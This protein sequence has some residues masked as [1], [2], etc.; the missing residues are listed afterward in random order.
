[1]TA[2]ASTAS[3]TA[4]SAGPQP[5]SIALRV[6]L[7]SS[8]IRATATLNRKSSTAAAASATAR[9][10]TLRSP[11]SP[12]VGSA[13]TGGGDVPGQP[14]GRWPGTAPTRCGETSA[15]SMS[16]SGG[17]A[18]TIVSRTA[19]TPWVPSSSDSRT[20]L[21]RDLLMAE[22]FITTMPWFSSR[23]NGSVKSTSPGRAA[24]W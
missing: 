13:P 19:S 4:G 17:P 24:P 3:R 18:N 7:T 21:P 6:A 14:P 15:Q 9:W 22:P 5:V 23:V 10:V 1:M 16:S 8:I 12:V 20:R 2:T 11:A